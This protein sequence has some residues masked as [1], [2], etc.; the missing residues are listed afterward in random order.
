[1]KFVEWAAAK[2]IIHPYS[3]EH[4]ALS[5][6]LSYISGTDN[7][8]EDAMPLNVYASRSIRLQGLVNRVF[9]EV[10]GLIKVSTTSKTKD[11]IKTVLINLWFARFMGKPVRYSR[12]RSA[13]KSNRR[14]GKLF[15]KYDR[16]IPVID[17]LAHLGYIQQKNGVW[18]SGKEI[19]RQSRMWATPRLWQHFYTHR[20]REPDFFHVRRPEELIIL[21]DATRQKHKV[22]YRNTPAILRY[23][24]ALEEYNDYIDR[25]EITVNLDG[26]VEIDHRFLTETL[27]HG[28][29][30]KSIEVQ[31]T[32]LC[33]NV[34][35]PVRPFI[36]QFPPT[37]Y[38]S[39]HTSCTPYHTLLSTMTQKKWPDTFTVLYLRDLSI[40][41]DIL[42]N[43][44]A[45]LCRHVT[46]IPDQNHASEFL[47]ERFP[48]LEI[49]LERLTLR[50]AYEY[51]HRVYNRKSFNLGGRAYGALH[52]SIPKH[53]RPYI[54]IDGEP[55]VELDYSAFHILMLYHMEGI[56][57]Q[58]DPY[59]VCEGAELRAI[60]KAVGLVAINAKDERSAYGAIRNELRD[61][62]LPLPAREKPLVSLVNT[63]REAHG[64]I[65]KYLFS[66]IGLTLQNKDSDIMNAILSS[67]MDR[68]I[69]GLSVYDSVIVQA[70]HRDTLH[71]TMVREYQDAMNGFKPRL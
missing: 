67:L 7:W 14:Y 54:H 19:G 1:M 35:H 57:Y 10:K 22:G 21:R 70:R 51:L 69:L 44:L 62:G 55:T 59:V 71:E 56:D 52:Q 11:A 9:D 34:V 20:L 47:A 27:Y 28:I 38:R 42:V 15:F 3:P 39:V 16:M 5:D 29:I 4:H 53:L 17:A 6:D 45:D 50:L 43:Y 25:H 41:V 63:F 32:T 24:R 61:R 2:P 33:T 37:P 40:A 30:N 13:Y 18:N 31:S 68:E 66:D 46:S 58:H 12:D 36:Q 8:Y 48:M 49:G 60:Y 23:R 64:P 65:A 26:A